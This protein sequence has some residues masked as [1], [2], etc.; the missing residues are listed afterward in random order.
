MS[1]EFSRRNAIFSSRRKYITIIITEF[2][3]RLKIGPV[4]SWKDVLENFSSTFL[5]SLKFFHPG[6]I[7]CILQLIRGLF[8]LI[9]SFWCLPKISFFIFRNF[10]SRN[11]NIFG[12]KSESVK[13][14]EKMFWFLKSKSLFFTHFYESQ[15]K[16]R[17]FKPLLQ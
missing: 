2:N 7:F 16:G 17:G 12:D 13:V 15:T 5:H 4:T 1:Y 10:F 11:E 14:T 8:V 6:P 9:T 3:C